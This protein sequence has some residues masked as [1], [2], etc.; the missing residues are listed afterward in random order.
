MNR[1]SPFI[2][3]IA[4]LEKVPR[5]AP[6]DADA[7]ARTLP[8]PGRYEREMAGDIQK[9]RAQA[10]AFGARAA[11]LEKTGIP[12]P[13]QPEDEQPPPQPR[14]DPENSLTPEEAERILQALRSK[15]KENKKLRQPR[16]PAGKKPVKKDW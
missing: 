2:Q 1:D 3:R 11:L 5:G 14:V 7:G 4:L 6:E 16:V 10:A 13:R 8:A 15:E 9:L 12:E